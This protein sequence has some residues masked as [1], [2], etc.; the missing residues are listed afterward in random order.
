MADK[1]DITPELCRQLLRYEPETGKLFWKARP[2]SFFAHSFNRWG[3]IK[4]A[5]T[6]AL[7]WNRKYAG[8]EAFTAN[9]RGYRTGRMFDWQYFAHR[10]IWAIVYGEWPVVGM[11]IDHINGDKSDNRI[12]NLRCVSHQENGQ[13]AKRPNNNTSGRIGVSYNRRLY[14]L[15]TR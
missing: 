6:N 12:A 2:A 10:V 4:T 1:P 13:N 8:K 15:Q 11:D 5:E 3:G 7:I 9:S 14:T